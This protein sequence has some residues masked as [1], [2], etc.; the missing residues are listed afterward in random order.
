MKPTNHLVFMRLDR[1]SN[2]VDGALDNDFRPD[3]LITADILEGINHELGDSRI[4]TI[5][6]ID[7]TIAQTVDDFVNEEH[8]RSSE[9]IYLTGIKLDYKI[10]VD[11]AQHI[12]DVGTDP[13]GNDMTLRIM[14]VNDK[15]G[16]RRDCTPDPDAMPIPINEEEEFFDQTSKR[17]SPD[18]DFFSSSK[19]YQSTTNADG[20]P[21]DPTELKNQVMRGSHLSQ[22]QGSR[23]FHDINAFFDSYSKIKTALNRGR[24]TTVKEWKFKFSRKFI[25]NEP[26]RRG[27]LFV[28]MKGK[29]ITY[30]AIKEHEASGYHIEPSKHYKIIMFWERCN[31]SVT[32]IAGNS[33]LVMKMHGTVYW[34]DE[35]PF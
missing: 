15:Y 23:D 27:S 3:S 17:I 16:S 4:K 22:A 31:G 2:N 19:E 25:G 14:M 35:A 5:G 12:P 8:E 32:S 26:C 28:G 29:K 24:Y 30:S 7:N 21:I 1:M 6:N 11:W 20:L 33:Q 10:A 18:I 13:I 9:C 34:K